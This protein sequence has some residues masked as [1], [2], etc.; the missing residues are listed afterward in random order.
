MRLKCLVCEEIKDLEFCI[1]QC[2]FCKIK[3]KE[4]QR[5]ENR[6]DAN[7]Y[8]QIIK[9]EKINGMAP[10]LSGMSPVVSQTTQMEII[11]P[12]VFN[13]NGNF[14]DKYLA[15]T[16]MVADTDITGN[17]RLYLEKQLIENFLKLTQIKS[18]PCKAWIYV[19][20]YTK[21]LVPNIHGIARLTT[22]QKKNKAISATNPNF[23]G[24]NKIIING[25]KEVRKEKLKMLL[26]P[27]N[28]EGWISYMQENYI[29]P[30]ETEF[31]GEMER[32]LEGW[33]CY[34]APAMYPF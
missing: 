28:V 8:T 33:E 3:T 32:I 1:T 24:K 22:E 10:V 9:T 13:R 23:K 2:D 12:S 30:G 11:K 26:R 18:M 29:V 4:Y 6:V 14:I 16:Y 31:V 27:I 15:I 21:D 5:L 17:N 25:K 34:Q 20:E 19:V 7:I